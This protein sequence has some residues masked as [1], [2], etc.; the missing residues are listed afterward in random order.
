ML[1]LLMVELLPIHSAALD[2]DTAAENG[3]DAAAN[4]AD[5]TTDSV[6]WCNY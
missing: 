4:A 6:G 5:D 2:A 3:L 1:L